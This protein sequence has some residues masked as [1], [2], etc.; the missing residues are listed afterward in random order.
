VVSEIRLYIEGDRR[1]RP[2]FGMF[3]ERLRDLAR[4]RRVGWDIKLCGGRNSAF[5]DFKTALDQHPGAFNIL[6]L[7]SE[8]PLNGEPW[9]HLRKRDGRSTK[10]S[11]MASRS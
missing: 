9:D 11:F 7:D 10:K 4:S 3:F 2:G 1:L 6:L 5:D 8:G